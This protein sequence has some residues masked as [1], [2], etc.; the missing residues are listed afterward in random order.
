MVE[1]EL[2]VDG[3]GGLASTT[4]LGGLHEMELLYLFGLGV[5][6]SEQLEEFDS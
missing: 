4:V 1:T 6:L 3:L 5:V 2:D